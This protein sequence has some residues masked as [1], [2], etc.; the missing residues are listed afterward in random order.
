MCEEQLSPSDRPGWAFL[1]LA[2]VTQTA[3]SARSS[4]VTTPI[5]VAIVETRLGEI[6][7]KKGAA[8]ASEPLVYYPV[9]T[10]P[11]YHT[12]TSQPHH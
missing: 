6:C 5:V 4:S 3:K 8:Y 2:S 1:E 10:P 12:G 9:M 7:P 11:P